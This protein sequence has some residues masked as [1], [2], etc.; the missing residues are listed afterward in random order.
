MPNGTA[1]K[2]WLYVFVNFPML[3]LCK[4]GISK[5][6]ERRARDV[7]KSIPGRAVILFAGK[8]WFAYPIEQAIHRAGKAL[9]VPFMGS[10]KTEWFWLPVGL[11]TIFIILI[12]LIL[13]YAAYLLVVALVAWFIGGQPQ[14][15]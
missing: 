10:G 9:N 8:V 6:A 3:F 5:D 2:Q 14:I 15:F 13:E 1:S 11:I 12:L 7:S 4:V